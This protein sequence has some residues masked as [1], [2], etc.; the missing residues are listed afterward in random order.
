MEP[1]KTK[2]NNSAPMPYNQIEVA[3]DTTEEQIPMSQATHYESY[4][5]LEGQIY[6]EM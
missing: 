3:V 5:S 2:W 6:D 4:T 1:S